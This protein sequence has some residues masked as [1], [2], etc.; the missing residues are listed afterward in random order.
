MF[1]T[2]AEEVA[3]VSLGLWGEFEDNGRWKEGNDEY[4]I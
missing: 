1:Q 2:H 4:G 3:R